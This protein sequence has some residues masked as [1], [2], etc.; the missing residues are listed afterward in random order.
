MNLKEIL[1]AKSPLEL[2]MAAAEVPGTEGLSG[3]ALKA[4]MMDV[5]LSEDGRMGAAAA[6][7]IIITV[8]EQYFKAFSEAAKSGS[9]VMKDFTLDELE[10]FSYCPVTHVKRSGAR[11][12]RLY[13]ASEICEIWPKM[14]VRWCKLHDDWDTVHAFAD[15]A[16]R[17]YGGITVH[18]LA[19]IL[20]RFLGKGKYA[21]PMIDGVLSFRA[22]CRD[23]AH[24]VDDGIIYGERFGSIFDY[25]EFAR[26]RDVCPRW[27]TDDEDEFF[28]YADERYFEKTPQREALVGFFAKTFA[29]SRDDAESM[30]DDI[31][32]QLR[33]GLSPE[34][35]ADGFDIGFLPHRTAK[36]L[37]AELEGLVR[38]VRENM[39]L[40]EYNGNTFASLP[41][42]SPQVRADSKTGRND[43]CPCGSGLKYKKCCGRGGQASK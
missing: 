31:Q 14:C 27:E 43:P 8:T 3:E 26:T 24:Y 42:I 22:S 20:D 16:V 10:A 40:A 18:E 1:D 37:T 41:Q 36:R 19:G 39:R 2:E 30:A 6:E 25:R 13:V 17:L 23:S 32:A 34:E 9:T 11:N 5:I 28:D 7:T 12:V 4:E 33:D 35:V 15:A 38:E 29:E 21:E